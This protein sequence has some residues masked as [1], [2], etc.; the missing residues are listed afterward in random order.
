MIP[1]TD[2]DS[3]P[4]LVWSALLAAAVEPDSS[5]CKTVLETK[6]KSNSK[7]SQLPRKLL[8]GSDVGVGISVAGVCARGLTFIHQ[9]LLLLPTALLSA[10]RIPSNSYAALAA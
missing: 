8:G 1:H 9:K 4:D 6:S 5:V 2:S 3:Y 10:H 7:Y